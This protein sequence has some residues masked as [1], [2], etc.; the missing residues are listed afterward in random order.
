MSYYAMTS[1]VN[2]G[3]RIRNSGIGVRKSSCL[4]E[5]KQIR[6]EDNERAKLE[7]KQ[8]EKAAEAA[9]TARR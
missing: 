4:K 2:I 1:L 6:R 5:D 8:L 9:T 3:Q 7:K